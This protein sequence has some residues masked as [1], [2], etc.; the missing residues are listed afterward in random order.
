M[1]ENDSP[2]L[3]FRA[4]QA[5]MDLRA[6]AG[7]QPR[8]AIRGIA[9]RIPPADRA[10]GADEQ[11]L[12][13]LILHQ[14][15]RLES[16]DDLRL[17]DALQLAASQPQADATAFTAATAI[18]LADRLQNG[19]GNVDMGLYWADF[20]PDY[21][22]LPAHDRAAVLQ[23]FLTG[24]D[25]GRLR[26]GPGPL[27]ARLTETTEAVR[28]DLLAAAVAGRTQLIAGVLEAAGDQRAELIL[29][30]LRSLLA[31][32][33]QPPLTGDSP[34]FAPLMDIAASAGHAATLPA[35]VLL[36]AEAVLTGDEEGWFAI[37]LWPESIRRWLALDR[38]AGRPILSGLR[39]LYEKDRDWV[40]MPDR[41]VSPKDMAEVPLLP[42]LDG[43]FAGGGHGTRLG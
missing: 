25:L 7:R 3:G 30:H 4:L 17:R 18:L 28:A 37:T 41:R 5:V 39:H 35:T 32:S 20:Q 16:A 23:G 33:R 10:R 22:A 24:A 27:P 13:R 11:A 6:A 21:L 34:L 12:T 1:L 40:P 8:S 43:S 38:R 26:P 36:M 42:V 19:L 2:L 29:P 14:G 15:G 9:A 31:G